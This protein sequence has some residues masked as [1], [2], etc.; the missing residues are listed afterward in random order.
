M[1][2]HAVQSSTWRNILVTADIGLLFGYDSGVITSTIGQPEF[3]EY[4]GHPS[5]ATTGGVV[6]SLTGGAIVGALSVSWLGDILG[7]KKTIF[8]GG[9]I[10]TLG[11]ALQAG[12]ATIGMLIA[13]RVFLGIAVG[14]LTAMVPMYCVSNSLQSGLWMLLITSV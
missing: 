3:I 1:R 4:F 7:R 6:S 13:G 14:I 12:A 9:A 11:A 10:S 2:V 8:L 5:A